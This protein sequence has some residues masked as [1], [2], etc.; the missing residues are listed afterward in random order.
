MIFFM[1]KIKTLGCGHGLPYVIINNGSDNM[2]NKLK[3]KKEYKKVNALFDYL[4]KNTFDYRKEKIDLDNLFSIDIFIDLFTKRIIENK[5][6]IYNTINILSSFLFASDDKLKIKVITKT[7]EKIYKNDNFINNYEKSIYSFPSAYELS[8]SKFNSFIPTFI[9]II[10]YN[11]NKLS[12]DILN[13]I[14]FNLNMEVPLEKQNIN[15][16]ID[17][18]NSKIEKINEI[19]DDKNN[20]KNNFNL[21]YYAMFITLAK[22]LYDD[23]TIKILKNIYIEK[24]PHEIKL[25]LV[26]NMILK[27][28]EIS[29]NIIKIMFE[30]PK[31]SFS[32]LSLLERVNAHKLIPKNINLTQDDIAIINM[33]NWLKYYSGYECEPLDL[34]IIDTIIKNNYKYY[35]FSFRNNNSEDIN[36]KMI[37]ISQGYDTKTLRTNGIGEDYSEFEKISDNYINQAEKLLKK[38]EENL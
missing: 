26:E 10:N 20:T 36:K 38:L 9:K 15:L 21:K 8:E 32:T 19:F 37:G 23:K 4:S 17:T 7:L 24:L 30:N 11:I 25:R 29:E 33:D 18:M 2:F 13:L 27:E 3:I 16:L 12:I 35:I 14:I 5:I 22:Y 34:K 28:I 31:D 1:K 6:S